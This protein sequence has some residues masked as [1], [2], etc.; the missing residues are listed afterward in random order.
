MQCPVETT[1]V[2]P[3]GHPSTRKPFDLSAALFP[4]S[5]LI[6]RAT[7]CRIVPIQLIKSGEVALEITL[8][9]ACETDRMDKKAPEQ[10][11]SVCLAAECL[12]SIATAAVE[13]P[14]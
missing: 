10:P 3:I 7:L 11:L 6:R 9:R 12:R 1:R 2:I 13:V 4:A 8:R 5:L 14:V